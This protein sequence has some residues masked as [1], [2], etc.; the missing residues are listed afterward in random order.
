[1]KITR[2]RQALTLSTFTLLALSISTVIGIDSI[3]AKPVFGTKTTKVRG[4]L[5]QQKQ[6]NV[7]LFSFL[8]GF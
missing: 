7:L 4:P 5:A 8:A 1:M 6:Q 3:L 2:D